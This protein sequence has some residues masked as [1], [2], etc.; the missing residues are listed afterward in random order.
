MPKS[1]S[2]RSSL[3]V[4][5]SLLTFLL[6]LTGGMGLYTSTHIITSLIYHGIMSASMLAALALLAVIWFMLRNKFLKP[7]DN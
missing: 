1:L 6:L 7:L 2:I 5:L 3:L 4:L